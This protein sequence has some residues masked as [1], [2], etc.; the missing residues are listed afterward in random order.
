MTNAQKER[1]ILALRQ[2]GLESTAANT[3]GVTMKEVRAAYKADPIFEE[4]AHESMDLATDAFEEEAIR[5][6]VDGVEKGIY[7]RGFEVATETTY[8]DALLVKVLA[9]RRPELYGNKTEIT[10]A[11]GGPIEFTIRQF[12]DHDEASDLA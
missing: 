12:A 9:A 11:N 3:A 10:G 4:Q 7:F 8:S 1:Y 5:R 2:R 6:A